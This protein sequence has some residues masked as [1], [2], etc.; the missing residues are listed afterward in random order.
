MAK[1]LFDPL[2]KQTYQTAKDLDVFNNSNILTPNAYLAPD[3]GIPATAA[4]EIIKNVIFGSNSKYYFTG[5]KDITA[6]VNFQMWSVPKTGTGL[7]GATSIFTEVDN[8]ADSS[9]KSP[10]EEFEDYLYYFSGTNTLRRYGLL[11]GSPSAGNLSTGLSGAGVAL[12]NHRGLRKLF[13]AHSTKVGW[14]DGSTTSLTALS[15]ATGEIC[16]GLDEYENFVLV[17]VS[18]SYGKSK[19]YVWNGT[20]STVASK[21]DLGDEWLLTFKNANGIIYAVTANLIEI[22]V[23]A[24]VPGGKSQL[25]D[26]LPYT[27]RF[28]AGAAIPS[29]A[30]SSVEGDIFSFALTSGAFAVSTSLDWGIYSYGSKG[31]NESK[32]LT[33]DRLSDTGATNVSFDGLKY[34]DSELFAFYRTAA[35]TYKV[36]HTRAGSTLGIKSAN[37]VYQSNAFFLDPYRKGKIKRVIIQHKPLP[38]ST[39]FKVTVKHFGDYIRNGTPTTSETFAN[40]TVYQTFN[41]Q[42]STQSILESPLFRFC[43]AAQIQIEFNDINGINAAE[44]IFPIICTVET[45]EQP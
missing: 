38:S 8:F 5:Q 37:G 30:V 1:S 16:R 36:I 41:T 12:K 39:G 43:Q 9:P 14:Y 21:I 33:L 29:D 28:A 45:S 3:A 25:I 6:V 32:L 26:V 13:F 24:C 17:G 10:I 34:A 18:A 22:R 2:E 27:T 40:A 23:Y 35:S 4:N 19:I 31:L 7:L 11:S 15:L 44:I 42:Y 20:D